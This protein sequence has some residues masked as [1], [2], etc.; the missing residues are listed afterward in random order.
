[1]SHGRPRAAVLRIGGLC[2]PL[3]WTQAFR[4]KWFRATVRGTLPA[5][6]GGG[7]MSIAGLFGPVFL[8]K[9]RGAGTKVPFASEEKFTR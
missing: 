1:M 8:V 5:W 7:V 6:Q 3:E 9:G 4:S 2:S